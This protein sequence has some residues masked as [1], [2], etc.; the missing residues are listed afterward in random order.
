MRWIR[1]RT[2]ASVRVWADRKLVKIYVG[3][4]LIKMHE[5]QRPGGRSTGAADY[6]AHKSAYALRDV[7]ALRARVETKGTHVGQYAARLLGGPLPWTKMRLAYAL[8][9]LCDKFGDGRVEAICQSALAF[10][11]VDVSRLTKMFKSAAKPAPRARGQGRA[12]RSASLRSAWGSP[13]SLSSS[14]CWPWAARR[15]VTKLQRRSEAQARCLDAAPPN[16]DW[17]IG[18]GGSSRVD[19]VVVVG[20][21]ALRKRTQPHGSSHRRRLP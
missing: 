21:A 14:S 11:V 8:L 4:E 19:V 9:A 5:R 6:P 16:E 20:S 3:T 1:T 15:G 12:A 10:D 7:D 18:C 2:C 13:V 17:M